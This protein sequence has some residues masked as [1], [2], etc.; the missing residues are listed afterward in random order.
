VP[1]ADAVRESNPGVPTLLGKDMRA[2]VEEQGAATQKISPNVQ[3]AADGT[4]QVESS[5][6][7]VQRGATET[8]GAS[9]QVLSA[10]QS[11]SSESSRLKHEVAKFMDSVRAA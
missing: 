5:I 8:G 10:A 6:A 4:S 2:A 1:P 9:A 3:R 7:D 11:L